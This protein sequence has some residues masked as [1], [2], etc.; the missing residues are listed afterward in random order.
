MSTTPP[1]PV[2]HRP[3]RYNQALEPFYEKE[4]PEFVPLR[5]KVK[6]ILQV[7]EDLAEIVQLVGK[8]SRRP[9]R[10]TAHMCAG[11]CLSDCLR[12]A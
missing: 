2:P 9:W 4:Y 1:H 7:E 12:M 10:R 6:E 11:L 3:H 8:V 5:T